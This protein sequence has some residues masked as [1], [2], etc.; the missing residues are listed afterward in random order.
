MLLS[1]VRVP[2]KLDAAVRAFELEHGLKRAEAVRVLL[3]RGLAEPEVKS[4]AVGSP[5]PA[6]AREAATGRGSG[7]ARGIARDARPSSTSVCPPHPIARK[8][9][10]HGCGACGKEDAW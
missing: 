5:R 10:P 2:A 1:G 3:V 4:R 9:G 6:A 8:I 7:R